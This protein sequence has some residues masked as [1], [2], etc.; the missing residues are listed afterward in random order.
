[1]NKVD[2]YLLPQS[3]LVP[4]AKCL[5]TCRCYSESLV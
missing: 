4:Q 5:D 2:Q 3:V 1:M